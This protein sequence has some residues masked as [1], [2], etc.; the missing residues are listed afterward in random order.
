MKIIS[1]KYGIRFLFSLVFLMCLQAPFS[2]CQKIHFNTVNIANNE[3]IFSDAAIDR[4]G[5]FWMVGYSAGSNVL[6]K[7]DGTKFTEFI[8]EQKNPNS[9][10]NATMWRLFIDD[11]NII[12]IGYLD[13]GLDRFDPASNTFTHYRHNPKDPGSLSNDS[14]TSILKDRDGD[15]WIATQNGLNKMDIKT[16][17]CTHF[18]HEPGNPQSLSYNTVWCMCIDNSGNLWVGC[19]STSL[20]SNTMIENNMQGGLNLFNKTNNT[21]TN[22]LHDSSDNSSIA[23]NY[24]SSIYSDRSGI[25]WIGTLGNHLDAM[26]TKKGIFVHYD[27]DP[28]H[29]EKLSAP[30]IA[31]TKRHDAVSFI[32]RDTSGVLW[33]GTELDGMTGYDTVQKI[34]KHFGTSYVLNQTAYVESASGFSNYSAVKGLTSY[35]GLFWVF[36]RERT[37]D[38]FNYNPINI[39]IPSI[40]LRNGA[41]GNAFYQQSDGRI[42]WVGTNKGLVRKDLAS[43]VEKIWVHEPLNN[44]SLSCDTIGNMKVDDNGI[45]W[46]ATVG[47]GLCRFDPVSGNFTRYRKDSK[48]KQSI[49]GN[50]VRNLWIDHSKNIWLGFYTGMDMFNI[51][52]GQF[53]HYEHNSADSTSLV[54]DIVDNIYEDK[55]HTIWAGT[56]GGLERLYKDR[57]SFHHYLKKI[58]VFSIFTD[59]SGILWVGSSDGLYHYDAARDSFINFVD[60]VT[61]HHLNMILCVMED[62]DRNLWLRSTNSIIKIDPARLKAFVYGKSY[63]VTNNFDWI[64]RCFK[65]KDGELF[66]G[67]LGGYNDFFPGQ[68]KEIPPPRIN[69]TSF[70]LLNAGTTDE[71][72]EH[73][74]IRFN[75]SEVRLSHNQN[76]FSV[77]FFALHYNSPGEVKYKVM[78]QNYDQTWR[79]MGTEHKTSFFGVMPGKYLLKIKAFNE[80]GGWNEKD[81]SILVGLPWWKTWWAYL[82]YILLA[83]TAIRSFVQYRSR[84][85][86]KENTLLER[87]VNERTNDLK[88]S[89][90]EL[91]A[92]QQQLIQSEKMASL[93]ELTAGIA[94]EI[95]NPLNFVNN[96]SEL[97][98]ELIDET[99]QAIKTG[100]RDEA[101]ELLTTLKENEEKINHHGKRADAIVKSMLQHSRLSAGQRESIDINTLADEYLR[102]AYHGLRANGKEF[103]AV[104]KTDFDRSI[105]KVN[106]IPQDIGRVLL[107]IYNNAF[108]A[109]REKKKSAEAE[110]EPTVLVKTMKVGDKIE[111]RVKDNGNGIPQT[112]INKIFQPFFTTKPTGHG[113]GLGLSLSYDIVK[114][115][116]GEIIV[117]TAEGEFTEFVIQ[118]PI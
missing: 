101:I 112:V 39:N 44:N 36:S 110:Y 104:M 2:F 12:W 29:P 76:S 52:T 59:S 97:N 89:L 94:H 54:N 17:K 85:L 51:R 41:N 45:F 82:L 63:G 75:T 83:G 15:L 65:G 14:V 31:N 71:N 115:H 40:S 95:Q 90:E 93:G 74:A 50:L 84:K 33:V 20:F 34:A 91:K 5:Y 60:P 106:F 67:A 16:G 107:N 100:D 96:F 70:Q 108:Y 57:K 98:R 7:Y 81:I 79:D 38:I 47:G 48:D 62:N 19:A 9:P 86:I 10:A 23:N 68:Q 102:L 13:G 4:Q 1:N 8:H 46:I 111:I 69:I 99:S 26:D 18:F 64:S 30:P 28:A 43:G 58:G 22:Y 32:S 37:R 73:A 117:N 72:I 114:A 109:V 27:Y 6:T 92:T 42:L 88:R 118:L 11:G 66:F 24:I 55:N 87:K 56:F 35:D 78:L 103:N 25:I 53:I 49:G 77:D 21:F 116:G 80:D 3:T 113:T 61:G 105:A